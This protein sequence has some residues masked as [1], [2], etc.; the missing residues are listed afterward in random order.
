[1]KSLA[2]PLASFF[3]SSELNVGETRA[4]WHPFS[5]FIS[6]GKCILESQL[7][8]PLIMKK[9]VH[10]CSGARCHNGHTVDLRIA[11]FDDM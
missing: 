3:C 10:C 1:M 9:A 7:F 2:L 4:S 5:V 8:Q 6:Q 11:L